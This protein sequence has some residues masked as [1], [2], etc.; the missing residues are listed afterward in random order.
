MKTEKNEKLTCSI[1]EQNQALTFSVEGLG[2]ETVLVNELSQSIRDYAILHGLKQKIGDAAA[3]PRN[4]MTGK[5][6]TSQEKWQAVVE[7]VARLR[8]GEWNR[9]REGGS[10]ISI[11]LVKALFEFYKGE[12]SLDYIRANLANKTPQERKALSL[13]PKI[14]KIIEKL[15]REQ[16]KSLNIDTDSLLDDF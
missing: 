13:N 3:I 8:G 15:E 6:A 7:M 10:N 14:A 2:S 16:V 5:S 11:L 9:G 1:D 12:K 4:E